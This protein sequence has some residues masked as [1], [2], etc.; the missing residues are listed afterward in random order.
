MQDEKAD[1]LGC[2]SAVGI[3]LRLQSSRCNIR[4]ER[5]DAVNQRSGQDASLFPVLLKGLWIQ[6]KRHKQKQGFRTVV[7][8]S[9]KWWLPPQTHAF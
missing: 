8:A 9:E 6:L 7:M 4:R 3:K 2:V 1:I 5:T